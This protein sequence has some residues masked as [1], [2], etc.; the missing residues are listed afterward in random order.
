MIDKKKIKKK[1]MDGKHVWYIDVSSIPIDKMDYYIEAIKEKMGKY[2]LEAIHPEIL[3]SFE[4]W[5][6]NE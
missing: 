4:D 1:I 2:D 6:S 5:S 3:A